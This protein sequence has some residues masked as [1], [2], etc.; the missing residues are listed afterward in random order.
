[1]SK[2]ELHFGATVAKGAEDIARQAKRMEQLG[3]EYFAVGEHFMRGDPPGPTH[4]SLPLLGVA[5][6][7]TETIRL[8]SSILLVPFYEP[9]VLARMTASLDLASAG[10]LTLGV[11][12]GGE[13]PVEFQAANLDVRQRGRRTDE[14]LE[15]LRRL[16][17][18]Q[19]VTY[20]GRHFR[21]DQAAINP[22]PVQKPG[23]PV[24]VSG[25]RDAAMLRAVNHGEGW[26][27]YFY[28][29]ER[30]RTSVSKITESAQDMGR[31]LGGFQWAYFPYISIYPTVEEAANVAARQLGGQ[32][33]YGGDFINIVRNYCILG[34]VEQCI[35]R[36]Q[37]YVD[38]GVCYF[39][40]SITCL[41][42]DED[43]HLETIAN[44]IIPK[45]R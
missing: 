32:Y 3:F 24:W 12:V 6:G 10:R 16:W 37:E 45:C 38:A 1:M 30:Y 42:G 19:P 11:G 15:A 43:R 39:I 34:S 31:D 25:R 27:P 22:P 14:C 2:A 20:E 41:E 7:A 17:T 21:L 8:L 13:F 35:S 26:M 36:I 4:A 28:S 23:P 18:G 5:A 33:L 44:E 40:F 9:L 29:P